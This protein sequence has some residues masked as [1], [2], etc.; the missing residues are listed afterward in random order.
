MRTARP[1]AALG[2]LLAALAL[3]APARPAPAWGLGP[4]MQSLAEVHGAAATFTET[5]TLALLK[6]PLETSG[7]LR[8]VA[9]DYVRKTVLAPS[10]QDFVLQNG[11]VTL[12]AAGRT[13]QFSLSQA[14]PL[15]GLVEGVRAALAGDLPTLDRYYTIQLSGGAARWQLLLRPRDAGLSRFL[16]WLSIGGSGNRITEIDTGGAHGDL[17][18]MSIDET[19]DHA[20]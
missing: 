20:P 11:V 19:I 17:T 5:K 18:R 1:L 7:T 8:Y 13:R 10:P 4:L 14:P 16:S 15:A 3:A 9:P 12:T 6:T 2:V